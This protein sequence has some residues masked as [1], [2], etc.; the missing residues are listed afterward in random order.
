MN[1][2]RVE[3]RGGDFTILVEGEVVDSFSDN[4]L[5]TGGIGFFCG[6][7]EKARL[8]WVEVSHQYDTLGKVC[9][10][11]APLSLAGVDKN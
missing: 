6:R 9:A 3:T 11:F 5:K 8:R 1:R 4:S 10:Y 7:G 2:F